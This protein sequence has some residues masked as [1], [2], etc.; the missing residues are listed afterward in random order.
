MLLLQAGNAGTG[1]SQPTRLKQGLRASGEGGCGHTNGGAHLQRRSR[2]VQRLAS[3]AECPVHGWQLIKTSEGLLLRVAPNGSHPLLGHANRPYSHICCTPTARVSR[4]ASDVP[5]DTSRRKTKLGP[6][7]GRCDT[8]QL[9]MVTPL[10][11]ARAP[12]SRQGDAL[13]AVSCADTSSVSCPTAQDSEEAA[14]AVSAEPVRPEARTGG[15]C[16]RG[17]RQR[18]RAGRR[19]AP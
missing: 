2:D 4:R 10:V 3:Q 11:K 14:Q 6:S 8:E 15:A 7:P 17:G 5:R 9:N 19:G 13:L 1:A 12:R 18:A 16:A